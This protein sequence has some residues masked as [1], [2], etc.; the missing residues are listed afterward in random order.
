MDFDDLCFGTV[1]PFCFN[2]LH[3]S[4]S[5]LSLPSLELLELDTR[6]CPKGVVIESW[7]RRSGLH[8]AGHGG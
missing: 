4:Q 8:V 1:I 5:A 7:R 3:G 2:V 6:W